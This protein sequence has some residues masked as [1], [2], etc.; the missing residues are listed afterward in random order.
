MHAIRIIVNNTAALDGTTEL[1]QETANVTQVYDTVL[2]L[3]TYTLGASVVFGSF[4]PGKLIGAGLPGATYNLVGVSLV[5]AVSTP[6]AGS[7]VRIAAPPLPSAA[8]RTRDIVALDANSG[9][10]PDVLETIPV[11][12]K[13]A[14]FTPDAGGPWVIDCLFDRLISA[15][16]FLSLIPTALA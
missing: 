16:G 10:S 1:T 4:D 5:P 8:V 3:Q 11:S 2:G 15:K 12:H 13:L 14:F 6:D 9:I 7:V